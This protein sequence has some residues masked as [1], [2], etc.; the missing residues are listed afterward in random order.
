MF[1]NLPLK[2]IEKIIIPFVLFSIV[3]ISAVAQSS[4][5]S[6]NVLIVG[7]GSSHDF[8]RWFNLE[9]S[10]II[11]ETGAMVRY[12]AQPGNIERLFPELDILYLSNNQPLPDT[13]GFRNA[14]F[15]FVESGNGLLL[16]HAP[17]WYNWKDWPEYNRELAGGGSQ[18]HEEYGEFTV[19]VVDTDHPIMDSVPTSFKIKDELYHFKPD[20]SAKEIHVLAKGIAPETGEEYPI[21]WT[22]KHGNGRIVGL[23]L[24]HDGYAH[25]HYAYRMI[26]RNSIEWLDQ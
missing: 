22:L 5:E 23:T 25:Y 12:T 21:A 13:E 18:S 19:E 9:D 6:S 14:M 24:G 11:A 26:L 8:D 15:D 7:G 4:H 16:V 20:D 2:W 10:K 1:S 17:T 3:A